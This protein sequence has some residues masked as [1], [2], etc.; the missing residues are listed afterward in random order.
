MAGTICGHIR[1]PMKNRIIVSMESGLDGRNNTIAE[2]LGEI[3]KELSQW[4]PA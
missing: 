3:S 4:S 2:R 1:G